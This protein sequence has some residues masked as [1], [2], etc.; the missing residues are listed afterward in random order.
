MSRSLNFAT[1][2]LLL[3]ACSGENPEPQPQASAAPEQSVCDPPRVTGR[4]PQTLHEASGVAR[5][6]TDPTVLWVLNDD[7]PPVIFA[8][9]STG[10]V[11]N[12]VAVRNARN[13]DWETLAAARRFGAGDAPPL[14]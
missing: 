14:F 9:D 3:L 11:R 1:I 2:A 5:G 12:R 13:V 7:G 8:L 4:I 6:L 10:S